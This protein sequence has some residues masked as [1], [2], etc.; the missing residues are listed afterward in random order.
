MLPS[1]LLRWCWATWGL[2]KGRK[3]PAIRG[4][5]KYLEGAEYTG[6]LVEKDGN[7]IT[8]KGPGACLKFGL[9]LVEHLCGKEKVKELEEA[10]CLR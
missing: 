10:M 9:A 1:A 6:A 8:G 2:L 7:I 3:P 5:D 4:F